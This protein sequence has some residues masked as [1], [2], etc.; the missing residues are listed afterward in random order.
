VSA[1]PKAARWCA[2]IAFLNGAVWSVVTPPFHVPDETVHVSY[3]QRLAETGRIPNKPGAAVFSPEE[4]GVLNALNFNLVV[5]RPAE[6]TAFT[7]GQ[8]R[9][10]KQ[11]AGDSLGRVGGGGTSESSNQPPLYYAYES[12]GYLAVPSGNLLTRLSLMRLLSALI[13]ATTVVFVYLFLRELLPQPWTWTVGAL[14]VAFQPLFGFIS[15]GVTPDSLLFASSAALF[16]LLAR[17]FRRGLSPG[18]GVGLGA[19]LA[20]GLLAKLNF[21]AFL[22]GVF[23]GVTL[24]VWRERRAPA[25]RG[26]VVGAGAACAIV[27]SLSG[28]YVALNHLVWDRTSWGGG[29]GV[30]TRAATGSGAAPTDPITLPWQLS[31]T[32]QLYLPRLPFMNRQFPHFPP[33]EVWYKGFIGRFGWLDTAFD[34]WVYRLTLAVTIPLLALVAVAL[35]RARADLR[36][37]WPEIA[38]YAAIVAGL[39]VSVGLLGLRYRRNTGYEFEQARYLLPFLALYGAALAGAAIGA[40]RRFARPVGAAIVALAAVHGLFAQL[41]VISRFYG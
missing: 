23:L 33:W 12:L 19:V 30:A 13:G 1:L 35:F 14:A 20:V 6:R 34:L 5:G 16:W 29:L 40:G 10:V 3:L 28:V 37:R 21:V 27:G 8:N 41:L 15:S 17:A 36:R 25:L 9:L 11:V 4:A 31:Y 7:A 24:L 26:S 39:L 2:L 38:T 18:L 22:P 32:W